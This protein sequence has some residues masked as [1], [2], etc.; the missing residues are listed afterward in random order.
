MPAMLFDLDSSHLALASSGKDT[1]ALHPS[2]PLPQLYEALLCLPID[3]LHG[4]RPSI[5]QVS[6]RY[7]P[8]PICIRSEII[9]ATA[10]PPYTAQRIWPVMKL[11]GH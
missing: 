4:A 7:S 8:S 3:R 5:A 11:P 9:A 6:E 10:T 2:L 1:P